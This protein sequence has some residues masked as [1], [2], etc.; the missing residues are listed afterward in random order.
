MPPF[1]A[2]DD[3]TNL[4][5]LTEFPPLCCL[6]GCQQSKTCDNYGKTKRFD[7]LR[8]MFLNAEKYLLVQ[9]GI[10]GRNSTISFNLLLRET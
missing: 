9:D 10:S 5:G 8:Q 4:V 7:W 3:G 1:Q 6:H 2:G